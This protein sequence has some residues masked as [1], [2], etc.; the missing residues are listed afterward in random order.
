MGPKA[1]DSIQA[2][3][4]PGHPFFAVIEEAYRQFG[5]KKPNDLEVCECC[6]DPQTRREFF[7][8]P[9]RDLPLHDLREW[10][11]A[12]ADPGWVS[13]PLWQYLL[14]R[15]LEVLAA[16]EP[17]SEISVEISLSR[18]TTGDPALWSAA[19]W[20]VL[21]QF[22][23]RFLERAMIPANPSAGRLAH[24]RLDDAL[25]M[26]RLSGWPLL[27]LIAQVT[28]MPGLALAER[29]WHDWCGDFWPG[30]GAIALT[31]FWPAGDNTLVHDFYTSLAL[32]ER[33]EALVLAED[34]AP[35]VAE[36]ALAVMQVIA[37]N[38]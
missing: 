14:P 9:I 33:M 25:C 30:Y 22:Q 10:Y 19:Q 31:S 24:L 3:L 5:R 6:M 36:H 28:A 16:G 34:A 29:L 1:S 7:N 27:D 12:A 26:F 13:Q 15:I 17:V 8:H 32:Q 37:D 11:F 2:R 23:R 21:D 35:L 18:H 38:R 4:E 20:A